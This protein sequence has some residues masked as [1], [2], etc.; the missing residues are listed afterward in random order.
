MTPGI[1][2][3]VPKI[4]EIILK[5]DATYDEMVT[6]LRENAMI[7]KTE[8]LNTDFTHSKYENSGE[9][10]L[11]LTSYYTD[12]ALFSDTDI[13]KKM[14]Q[15]KRKN[16]LLIWFIPLQ[17]IDGEINAL[18]K[19]FKGTIDKEGILKFTIL[20]LTIKIISTVSELIG[21]TVAGKNKSQRMSEFR[22][23]L[24]RY[25]DRRSYANGAS[26]NNRIDEQAVNKV[27]EAGE[28]HHGDKKTFSSR[29]KKNF[30][31][32]VEGTILH[33]MVDLCFSYDSERLPKDYIYREVYDLVRILAKE[34]ARQLP[35][36]EEDYVKTSKYYSKSFDQYKPLII[37]KILRFT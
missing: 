8:F 19:S 37:K 25:F 17:E 20:Y 1:D 4:I 22:K 7:K 30:E 3:P 27:V 11:T 32:K 9:L 18:S 34:H 36:T 31:G 2:S 28:R 21:A 24:E 16:K 5:E 10:A 29:A 14:I 35:K 15:I 23:W 26:N 12:L 33:G 6:A 13:L